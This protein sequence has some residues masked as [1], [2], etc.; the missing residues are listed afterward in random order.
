MN[1]KDYYSQSGDI[2]IYQNENMIF[3]VLRDPIGSLDCFLID[4]HNL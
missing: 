3:K 2:D 4:E 1:V